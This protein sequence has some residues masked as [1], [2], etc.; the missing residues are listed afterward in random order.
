MKCSICNRNTPKEFQEK[1]H[2]IPKSKG[3]KETIDV[4][5]D[6]GDQ[7]HTMFSLNEL[8]KN[9]NTLDKIK[10]HDKMV[11]Y[12]KF[13]RKRKGFGLCHKKLK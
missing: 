12:I 5:V 4:C 1:H 13:V 8:K 3:G 2:L 9:L 10:N 7:L 6:C 11:S